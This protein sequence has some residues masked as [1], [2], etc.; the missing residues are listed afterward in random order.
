ML[1]MYHGAVTRPLKNS[2]S[3]EKA[4]SCAEL[5]AKKI[6]VVLW[7]FFQN[8]DVKCGLKVHTRK[9]EQVSAIFHSGSVPGYFRM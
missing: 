3:T 7:L 1:S 8:V 6:N 5:P 4:L 9:I 2:V